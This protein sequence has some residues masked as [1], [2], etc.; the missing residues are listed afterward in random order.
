LPIKECLFCIFAVCYPS[1]SLSVTLSVS[2]IVM[3]FPSY[4]TGIEVVC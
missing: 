4:V 2:S 1:E 3:I